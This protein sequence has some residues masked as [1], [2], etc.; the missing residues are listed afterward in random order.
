[1][2]FSCDGKS[3]EKG[4]AACRRDEFQQMLAPAEK[5]F[6]TEVTG[7]YYRSCNRTPPGGSGGTRAARLHELRL[8]PELDF[9]EGNTTLGVAMLHSRDALAGHETPSP[10]FSPRLRRGEKSRLEREVGQHV[11]S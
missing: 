3:T 7:D 10:D 5:T 8:S 2:I 1:M 4:R 6:A 11:A 9:D